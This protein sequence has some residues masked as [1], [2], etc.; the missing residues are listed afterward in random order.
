M[1]SVKAGF[2]DLQTKNH[3]DNSR[4]LEQIENNNVKLSETLTKQFKEETEKLR[5]EL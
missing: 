5:A 1:E 3:R 2:K 4:L